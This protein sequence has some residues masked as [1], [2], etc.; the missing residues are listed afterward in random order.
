MLAERP[1]ARGKNLPQNRGALKP[2]RPSAAAELRAAHAQR[3]RFRRR[4][5]AAARELAIAARSAGEETEG[6]ISP[7]A[8]RAAFQL[9]AETM[10]ASRP[11][12]PRPRRRGGNRSHLRVVPS[13]TQ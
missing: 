12:R 5:V 6:A 13:G 7:E 9:G 1:Y 2:V 11:A 10:A 8:W 4:R 3:G